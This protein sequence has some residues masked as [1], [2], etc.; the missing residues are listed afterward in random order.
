MMIVVLAYPL[1]LSAV[2]SATVWACAVA[3]LVRIAIVDMRT[4]TIPNKLTLSLAVLWA[5]SAML[6]C[7]VG[8][9]ASWEPSGP[10]PFSAMASG[11]MRAGVA[12][13]FVAAAS[14]AAVLLASDGS[15]T[16]ATGS[17]AIGGGDVKLLAVL[18]LYLGFY[19]VFACL[20]G[21]CILALA[22][23]VV[24]C[25][26]ARI[27]RAPPP[28]RDFPFAPYIGMAFAAVVLAGLW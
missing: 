18:G 21:A 3:L 22:A 17:P 28:A 20:A 6:L 1:P 4:R 11:S 2:V 25:A 12:Q 5:A 26:V 23:Q 19:G 8:G 16:A 13:S 7:L 9:G 15:M 14:V 10:L 27:K 24:R